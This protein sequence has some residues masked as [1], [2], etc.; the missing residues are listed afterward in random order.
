MQHMNYHCRQQQSKLGALLAN[1]RYVWIEYY[2][3][4]YK[5]SLCY[6]IIPTEDLKLKK[7]GYVGSLQ[8]KQTPIQRH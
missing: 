3:L 5:E 8:Q 1:G 4:H 2:S 6:Y 7:E